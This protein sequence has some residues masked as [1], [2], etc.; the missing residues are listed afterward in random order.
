[1]EWVAHLQTALF[2]L[3][4][5]GKPL[6]IKTIAIGTWSWYTAGHCKSAM[7]DEHADGTLRLLALTLA[8]VR[9]GVYLIEE[10]ENGIHP[11]AVETMVQSLSSVYDAR[12]VMATHSPVILKH[13]ETEGR[14]LFRQGSRRGD[15]YESAAATIQN[16]PSGGR[17]KVSARPFRR[18]VL[19]RATLRGQ[20][21][22]P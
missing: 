9:R 12:R 22:S 2:D 5:V 17:K 18:R 15:R 16:W 6:Y 14:A 7:V 4:D 3:E 8:R 10:P 1:M 13:G 20:D 19:G 11:R 21:S